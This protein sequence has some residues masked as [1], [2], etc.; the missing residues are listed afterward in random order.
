LNRL[1][2]KLPIKTMMRLRNKNKNIYPRGS[3][4]KD[5]TE[6]TLARMVLK[7]RELKPKEEEAEEATEVKGAATEVKE[8]HSEETEAATEAEAEAV[9]KKETLT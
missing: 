7:R 3:T 1:P 5:S 8:A 6:I 9:S 2:E 4:T